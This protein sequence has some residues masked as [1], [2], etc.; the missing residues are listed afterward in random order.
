MAW[1]G[2]GFSTEVLADIL[3]NDIALDWPTDTWKVAL[4][5]NT[6]TPDYT[7]AVASFAYD[8]G[9]W[10]A[11]AEL[12]D[13]ANWPTGG[14]ALVSP[15]V[16]AEQP[17]AGQVRLDANDVS[18]ASTT[19]TDARGCLVYDDTDASDTGLLAVDFGSLFS[20]TNGTFQIAWD[21]NGVAYFDVW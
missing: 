2:S 11:A 9:V 1:G 21:T 3:G 7:V 8:A 6:I 20:T 15:A 17:A 16:D 12:D 18:Q 4:F 14:P 5:P 10:T 19:I 13:P